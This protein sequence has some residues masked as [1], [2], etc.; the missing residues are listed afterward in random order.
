MKKIAIIGDI[1]PD[2]HNLLLNNNCEILDLTNSSKEEL[3]EKIKDVDAI[4]IRTGKLG[5]DVLKYCNDLKIISRHGVG[6]DNIDLNFL[7]DNKIALSITGTA[8]AVS[9][10]EHVMT[11]FLYLC[12][13]IEK[14]NK[15]VREGNF[16]KK[17]TIPNFFELYKKNILILG[18]GRIGKSLAKKCLGFDSN[19]YVYDPYIDKSI[20]KN[21]NCKDIDFIDGLKIADF[22]SIHMPLNN[23]TK[24]IISKN[25]FL[26]MK[27]SSI[28]VNT[29]RG[30]I[31]NERDLF[32]ALNN[33][34][35]YGAGIDVY[36]KEPPDINNDLFKLDNIIFSPHNAAL[37]LECRKRMAIESCENVLYFLDKDKKL[38]INNIV[39]KKNI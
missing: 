16:I 3:T 31:I 7:N 24:N 25:E 13:L 12:K 9:V 26:V 1:H 32:W 34:E 19:V 39:N 28:I 38:N 37:T 10:S 21:A 27:K 36:E 17:K 11:M 6:Y 15:L 8:N 35:I 5:K 33:K 18:F 22:V 30:G 2:G 20:I 29:A 14:S 23:K 4:A